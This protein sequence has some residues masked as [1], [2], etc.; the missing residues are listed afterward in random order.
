MFSL[1]SKISCLNHP[2]VHTQ[3]VVRRFFGALD[4]DLEGTQEVLALVGKADNVKE[5]SCG[6]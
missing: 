5:L 4:I 2:T 3:E 6:V 1:T